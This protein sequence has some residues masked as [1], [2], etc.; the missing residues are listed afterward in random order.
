MA[1]ACAQANMTIEYRLKNI[2]HLAGIVTYTDGAIVPGAI[3][4]D[5]DSTYKH[6]LASTKTDA[7]GRFSFSHAKLGS[8]H[9]IKVDYPN[10]N[11]VHMPVKI[12][13]FAK[14]D[15]KVS[16]YPRT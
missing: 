4:A 13:P 1:L 15:L 6:V 11:E 8:R 16:L 2:R 3:V 7:N 12:W 5:C 10:F 9:Y 14:A